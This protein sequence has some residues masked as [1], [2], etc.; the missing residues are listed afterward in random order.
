MKLLGMLLK[1]KENKEHYY[2]DILKAMK[3]QLERFGIKGQELP[4]AE[5]CEAIIAE[6]NRSCQYKAEEEVEDV[7]SRSQLFR[8]KVR[9]QY[10]TPQL[11]DGKLQK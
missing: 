1:Q 2:K 8:E 3:K 4:N 11:Y 9:K 6:F 7:P 10:N 5:K